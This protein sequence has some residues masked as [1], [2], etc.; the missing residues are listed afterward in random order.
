[1]NHFDWPGRF[2]QCYDRAVSLYQ[3][4]NH[5]P[6]GYFDPPDRAFLA[7]IGCA[8]QEVY[9]FA[10]DWC[11]GRE[12][13]F[14]TVL[15]ITAVRRDYFLTVQKGAPSRLVIS[16]KDLP[17]REAELAGFAW[18]PRIIPKARAKLRGEMPPDLMYCCGGDR[19]FLRRVNVHP[20]DF[21]RAVWAAGDDDDKIAEHVKQASRSA[22]PSE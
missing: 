13:S 8:A 2:Q 18:L 5:Q 14:A 22:L 17:A 11:R 4:G 7:S 6:A 21:L 1:M 9:D 12:P 10:E 20:A 16:T 19:G 3:K 15:L